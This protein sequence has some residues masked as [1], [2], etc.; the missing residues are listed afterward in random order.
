MCTGTL[1]SNKCESS[2]HDV[3]KQPHALHHTLR[4]MNQTRYPIFEDVFKHYCNPEKVCAL[5]GLHCNR[6]KNCEIDVH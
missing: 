6:K 3:Q 5:V 4:Q 1:I 2:V